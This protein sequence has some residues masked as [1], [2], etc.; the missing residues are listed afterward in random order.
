MHCD[1]EL[2]NNDEAADYLGL[3]R[4]TLPVRQTIQRTKCSPKPARYSC[5][6]WKKDGL[7]NGRQ[8]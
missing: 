6:W 4:G 3:K 2:Y 8:K 5:P 7:V 1:N